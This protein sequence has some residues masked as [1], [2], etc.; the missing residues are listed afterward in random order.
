MTRIPSRV[1]LSLLLV[2]GTTGLAGCKLPAQV[3]QKI[4]VRKTPTPTPLPAVPVQ[5][6]FVQ[7]QEERIRGEGM[8]PKCEVEV[9]LP[10]TKAA[11]V[12][13]TRV[14]VRKVVD[15]LG[16]SLVLD[17]A[18]EARFE[19][20]YHDPYNRQPDMPLTFA[21]PMKNTSRKAKLLK[22]VTADVELYTPALD[23]S[24][25][26][27]IPNFMGEAG[28]P[29]VSQALKD[30]GVDVVIL[31]PEQLEK[32]KAAYGEAK[33]AEAKKMGLEGEA[34]EMTV[35]FS[36]ETFLSSSM[37]T[38]FLKVT[39]P[40]SRV[41]EYVFVNPAGEVQPVNRSTEAGI[42]VLGAQGEEPGPDWGL[43]VRLKTP[44]T[45]QRYTFTLRDVALP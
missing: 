19:N 41:Q 11:D 22:E 23:P 26:V 45:F 32:E 7:I 42:V 14:V 44:K 38:V 4:F 5:A 31:S 27:T 29:V 9:S 37:G 24:A 28:K 30:A 1:A 43:Q 40:N 6:E 10:G 25:V 17:D 34:L 39:D 13:A 15:D 36:V 8:T 16:A 21:V 2:F 35:R 33:R 3:L 18:A 20:A 12:A